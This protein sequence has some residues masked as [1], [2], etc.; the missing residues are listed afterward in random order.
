MVSSHVL[1]GIHNAKF[2]KEAFD[3][4]GMSVVN[5]YGTLK[6][7][8]LKGADLPKGHDLGSVCQ[9]ELGLLLDKRLQKSDWTTR[10]LSS[11]QIAYAALDAEVL[12]SLYDIFAMQ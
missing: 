2:E 11:E 9:R 4:I 1:K 12:L 5:I 6:A 3:H 7:S 8:R 10:P